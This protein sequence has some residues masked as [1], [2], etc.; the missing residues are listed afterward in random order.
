MSYLANLKIGAFIP[1]DS[2][3]HRLDPRFKIVSTLILLTFLF[4]VGSPYRLIPYLIFTIALFY[5]SKISLYMLLRGIKPILFLLVFA[6]IFQ[7]FF[8]PGKV[9]IKLG[10]L[11][12]TEE[13]LR[14]GTLISFRLLL[15]VFLTNLLT[16]TTSPVEITD[17]IEELLK[18]LRFAKVPSHE[19]AMTMSIALRFIPTLFEE[20][21][22]IMKAQM[23][24]GA[25][26][27]VG[28]FVKRIKSYI[29]LVIPLF[30]GVFRKAEE[31]A[32]AMETRC[33]RGGVGRTKMKKLKLK[34]L[35]YV[36]IVVLALFLLANSV[37]EWG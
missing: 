12:I 7:I 30:V 3:I 25:E 24:R 21:D 35:D 17:G 34:R 4:L 16:F 31:L 6:F 2:P 1:A 33:Y 18:F 22:R 29:P 11:S 26:F 5:L 32:V 27:G 23:A 9:L 19:I 8:T 14:S 28:G 37:W 36:G 13:G 10:F 15:L 20:A